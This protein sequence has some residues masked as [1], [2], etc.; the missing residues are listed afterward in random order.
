MAT[1]ISSSGSSGS[2]RATPFR[3]STREVSLDFSVVGPDQSPGELGGFSETAFRELVEKFAA[4]PTVKLLD[5]DPQLI[6]SAKR[7]RYVII[8]STGKLLL[9]PA[10]DSQQPYVKFDPVDVPP[11]LDSNDQTVPGQAPAKNFQ[12]LIGSAATMVAAAEAA[13]PETPTVPIYGAF[14]QNVGRFVSNAPFASA[15]PP[16]P[17]PPI[18]PVSRKLVISIATVFVLVAAASFWGYY[19]PGPADKPLPPAPPSEFDLVAT[20]ELIASL[21]KRFAG[22]YA[23]AGTDGERLLELR[24]DGTFRYQEFG[25]NVARTNSRNGTYVFAVRHGTKTPL[26]RASGLGT[27]D[28]LDE[29]KIFCQRAVF[30]R[31]P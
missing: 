19:G 21:K 10:N 28:L 12:T 13:T 2:N 8:P 25:T 31:L 5:G 7:G 1:L 18:R 22:T 20:P 24:A 4:I 3:V 16:P 11:F 9:R 23:T 6:V 26:I 30:N 14:P 27:I 17:P 15:P 29:K